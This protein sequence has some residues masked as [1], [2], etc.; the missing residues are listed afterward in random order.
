MAERNITGFEPVN[1][2]A[3]PVFTLAQPGNVSR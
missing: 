3:E 2:Q 1:T